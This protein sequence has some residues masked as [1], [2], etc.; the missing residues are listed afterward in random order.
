[1]HTGKYS[2]TKKA[3]HTEINVC[4]WELN[5]EMVTHPSTK[6]A[7]HRLTSFIETIMLP[8]C[9]TATGGVL[10]VPSTL[11]C[12]IRHYSASYSCQVSKLFSK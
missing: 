6:R 11:R 2:F 12:D 10:Q 3:L 7:Q 8:L 4:H 5:S 1:M 9:Q